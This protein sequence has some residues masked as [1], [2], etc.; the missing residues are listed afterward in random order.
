MR[1][2]KL[3]IEN[4]HEWESSYINATQGLG[5][6]ATEELELMTKWLSR[7]SSDPVKHRGSVHI[8]NPNIALKKTRE[9]LQERYAV[10]KMIEKALFGLLDNY[11]RL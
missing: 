6:T 5:L 10:P 9:C 11:P 1:P 2:G 4:Y 3:K 8:T 7:E